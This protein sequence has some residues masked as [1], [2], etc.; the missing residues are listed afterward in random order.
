M[1]RH[2]NIIGPTTSP[3]R[4]LYINLR[5]K[6]HTAFPPLAAALTATQLVGAVITTPDTTPSIITLSIPDDTQTSGQTPIS[7]S[8]LHTTII[9]NEPPQSTSAPAAPGH[10][11]QITSHCPGGADSDAAFAAFKAQVGDV[12]RYCSFLSSEVSRRLDDGNG[13][14]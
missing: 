5:M 14:G 3:T 11:C 12:P 7:S 8:T 2:N 1:G 13:T 4:I 9:V 6:P 10:A